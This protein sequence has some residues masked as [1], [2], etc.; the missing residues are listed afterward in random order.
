MDELDTIPKRLAFFRELSG[1][2]MTEV[3]ARLP[4]ARRTLFAH[5]IGH[6]RISAHDLSDYAK[7]YDVSIETLAD[8]KG[9]AGHFVKGGRLDERAVAAL[10]KVLQ[11]FFRD[12]KK[13]DKD[14]T[15]PNAK[16]LAKQIAELDSKAWRK[17]CLVAINQ[18]ER[19]GT[20]SSSQDYGT[21][22][23]YIL[24]AKD[25]RTITNWSEESAI[26]SSMRVM[27]LDKF[28][29]ERGARFAYEIPERDESMMDAAG[30]GFAPG[31]AISIAPGAIISPGNYVLAQLVGFDDFLFRIFRS[32]RPLRPNL[33]FD[34]DNS[35]TPFT[36]VPLNTRGYEELKITDPS[37]VQNIALAVGFYRSLI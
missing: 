29:A 26:S 11:R 34:S 27:P 4:N 25:L 32:A 6:R 21:E 7:L 15:T 30:L 2:T 28:A 37:D 9:M 19:V 12:A 13:Q 20:I 18:D 8:G 31:T 24:S 36:L 23:I 10:K 1:L 3:S 16:R 14:G 33:P 17:R 22:Y 5:E 35:F